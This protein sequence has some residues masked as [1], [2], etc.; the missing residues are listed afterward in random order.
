MQLMKVINSDETFKYSYQ[1]L[2]QYRYMHM[3]SLGYIV[4]AKALCANTIG[5]RL[6]LSDHHR[7]LATLF[8]LRRKNSASD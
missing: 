7:K 4:Q 6:H 5:L 2:R 1:F 3:A 8:F